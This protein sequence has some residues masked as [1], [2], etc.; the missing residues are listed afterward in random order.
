MHAL[1][2][3]AHHVPRRRTTA[4]VPLLERCL[5]CSVIRG[6][7]YRVG[8]KRRALHQQGYRTRGGAQ[9]K[10]TNSSSSLF[11]GCRLVRTARSRT[12]CLCAAAGPA[13]TGGGG[14]GGV[15]GV[16]PTLR[17]IPRPRQVA[18]AQRASDCSVYL[19]ASLRSCP[20]FK[21]TNTTFELTSPALAHRAGATDLPTAVA[22]AQ[23]VPLQCDAG[24]AAAA[25]GQHDTAGAGPASSAEV[26]PGGECRYVL[27]V[28]DGT[29]R[30]AREMFKVGWPSRPSRPSRR[31]SWI[32]LVGALNLTV[33]IAVCGRS[34]RICLER[35]GR[36]C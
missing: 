31:P 4:T 33:R 1:T 3:D 18:S 7:N 26:G 16:V 17:P 11:C 9:W 23:P 10:G 20:C 24:G 14:G 8:N 2:S 5:Q 13:A 35:G 12:R 27:L 15:P 21:Q 29:W 32:V 30:Q 19:D 28:I 6:R 36:C 25:D 34:S 22:A